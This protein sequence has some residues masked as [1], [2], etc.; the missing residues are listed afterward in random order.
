MFL[1]LMLVT[2]LA[3]AV[4]LVI[5]V[6]NLVKII[7]TLNAIGGTSAS[8]LAKLRWGLRAIETETGHLAPEV[9]ALNAE[10]GVIAEGLTGVDEHLKGTINAVVK[11]K[12]DR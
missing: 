10:L 3:G 11:Q 8:F 4:L 2:L 7:D 12:G 5:L 6:F 1:I 9:T